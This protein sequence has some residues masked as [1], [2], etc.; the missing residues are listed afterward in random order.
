MKVKQRLQLNVALPVF[1]AGVVLLV[2]IVS[3]YHVIRAVGASNIAGDIVISAFERLTLRN[4]YIQSGS[5]RAKVQWLSKHE[6]ISRLL[7][8]AEVNFKDPVDQR[9]VSEM[10]AN[11]ESINRIFSAI[12]KNREEVKKPASASGLFLETEER[13]LTQLNTKLYKLVSDAR[14]LQDS[15][16]EAFLS[17]L[18]L[19][20][21]G[22]TCIL[23]LVFAAA[24]V[25]SWLMGRLITKRIQSLRT[26]ALAIGEGKFDHK[27]DVGG[28][29]ELAELSGSFNAM[30][31]RLLGSYH[32]L[33]NEIGERKRAEELTRELNDDLTVKNVQLVSANKEL[34]AFIYSVSHD[35]RQPLRA[36]A[37]F[38]QM[39]QRGLQGELREKEKGYLTRVV[40]NAARMNNII[41]SM[42]SLSRI[43]RQE[44]KPLEID[45]TRMVEAIVSNLREAHPERRAEVAIESGLT[46]VADE[47]LM[48]AVL[49]NLIGNAWKFTTGTEKA[50]IEFGA[51]ERDKQTVYFVRDNGAGFDPAC[52]EDMFKPFHR[53]H[54]ESEYEGMG[55]GLSVVE[56]VINRHGGRVWAEGDIGKGATVFF[57]LSRYSPP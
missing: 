27:I 2:L 20:A 8:K 22:I 43:S 50:C 45:M 19:A 53:L 29:D 31:T 55:V 12:I 28:N 44:T 15:R 6:R 40:E 17:T 13:L 1:A 33:E 51:I 3:T 36:I 48:A 41:E 7:A 46:A 39:V 56:R 54:S 34:E 38:S 14:G 5:E 35:L 11:Q 42:L 32:D 24:I 52:T 57:T 9:I 21:W 25:N 18:H 49:E 16:R 30:A 10:I 37:S 47:G 23:I 26:G 4:D